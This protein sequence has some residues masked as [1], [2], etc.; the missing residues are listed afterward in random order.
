MAEQ[1]IKR[2]RGINS[3]LDTSRID[4]AGWGCSHSENVDFSAGVIQ[5]LVQDRVINL[6]H[7][8]F[9]SPTNDYSWVDFASRPFKL[10][11][12]EDRTFR[13]KWVTGN[14][15]FHY[16]LFPDTSGSDFKVHFTTS[17]S[18]AP[19]AF[20]KDLYFFKNLEL[21]FNYDFIHDL[22]F[23]KTLP[24]RQEKYLHT[25]FYTFYGEAFESPLFTPTYNFTNSQYF[26]DTSVIY[27]SD[28]HHIEFLLGNNRES[29]AF[30]KSNF[31]WMY[32]GT[33]GPSASPVLTDSTDTA[34]F[35]NESSGDLEIKELELSHNSKSSY[36]KTSG[37]TRNQTTILES[38]LGTS[39]GVLAGGLSFSFSVDQNSLTNSIGRNLPV[40]QLY[41]ADGRT[42]V[43][44]C[45]VEIVS[46]IE[47]KISFFASNPSNFAP[48]GA[49]SSS[50]Y[51]NVNFPSV[52]SLSDVNFVVHL[53]FFS[54]G[55]SYLIEAFDSS[56][57]SIA[58]G[59][60]RTE[61]SLNI[62]NFK[63]YK[64]LSPLSFGSVVKNL[65]TYSFSGSFGSLPGFT[66]FFN[67]PYTNNLWSLDGGPVSSFHSVSVIDRSTAGAS[68]TAQFLSYYVAQ[69]ANDF[70]GFNR[71]T[72]S[73]SIP[74]FPGNSYITH[75]NTYKFALGDYR[76][77]ASMDT[78]GGVTL[79]NLITDMQAAAT[80][81]V[82]FLNAVTFDGTNN[83]GTGFIF[84]NG[85]PFFS[86]FDSKDYIYT[87]SRVLTL[88]ETTLTTTF[89]FRDAPT[90][91][92]EIES[93]FIGTTLNSKFWTEYIKVDAGS[94]PSEEYLDNVLDA[95]L[96][97]ILPQLFI[98]DITGAQV[99]YIGAPEFDGV[100]QQAYGGML[101]GWKDST[102]Y[103]SE[104]LKPEL[105]SNT[106]STIFP[107]KIMG[108]VVG[109]QSLT[110]ITDSTSHMT[111]SKNPEAMSFYDVA[112]VGA[113]SDR[114]V[115]SW[116]GNAVFLSSYGLTV[117]SG[118]G[119]QVLTQDML[120]ANYFKSKINADLYTLGTKH[121]KCY[122]SL[123]GAF[124]YVFNFKS[125]DLTTTSTHNTSSVG[126]Y[127]A[128]YL[129][130]YFTDSVLC[131]AIIPPLG[132]VSAGGEAIF[133]LEDAYGG[134][135]SGIPNHFGRKWAREF[136]EF[137][138]QT[139]SVDLSATGFK[140]FDYLEFTGSGQVSVSVLDDK[141]IVI[142]D[143]STT[144]EDF[145]IAD[146]KATTVITLLA[147]E[148]FQKGSIVKITNGFNG[149][150]PG[151]ENEAYY[152]YKGFIKK[153]GPVSL[154]LADLV[155]F[156]NDV[157][158][159][160]K[161]SGSNFAF[162]LEYWEKFDVDP[163]FDL[164]LS[165]VTDNFL[166]DIK[167]GDSPSELG[168]GIMGDFLEIDA[169]LKNNFIFHYQTSAGKHSWVTRP[170]GVPSDNVGVL[171]PYTQADLTFD[172]AS[173]YLPPV[174][175]DS[176]LPENQL[177]STSFGA[178]IYYPIIPYNG[179]ELDF[180]TLE[181][182]RLYLPFDLPTTKISLIIKGTGKVTGI[183]IVGF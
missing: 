9:S 64:F 109:R 51:L 43:F 123:P 50:S 154:D 122:F 34:S 127:Q 68:T 22:D 177:N 23:P 6:V 150:S 25:F 66:A 124:N 116:E 24:P 52:P 146:G 14:G 77:S 126:G 145:T 94:D 56:G 117:L 183:K 37:L 133:S 108:V 93:I 28:F 80:F 174:T 166:E 48:F 87:G 91:A 53:D 172:P 98:S 11:G 95:D 110:I 182:S 152:R 112:N 99:E 143:S 65:D 90:L 144:S 100:A 41:S 40:F 3:L 165:S 45:Y 57:V 46:A 170:L 19:E 147:G 96:G 74:T 138:Y 121:E 132:G 78:T 130:D 114:C 92:T 148:S 1:T 129:D 4:E 106:F 69:F 175:P 105:F 55:A 161:T 111:T 42:E 12:F 136:K 20:T 151:G 179:F 67:N 81:N 59:V 142:F 181:G 139:S 158:T 44:T 101:V 125:G 72:F 83:L 70:N 76:L 113:I 7:T 149:L 156:T 153:S 2:F 71:L 103:W 31:E 107:S 17:D 140:S 60:V 61:A 36:L 39:S 63:A 163:N 82:S 89:T 119:Y 38:P 75:L 167:S 120:P 13:S 30:T 86:Q 79:G 29:L 49:F 15:N 16:T 62:D 141:G 18:T 178:V 33:W 164:S 73:P 27:T 85:Y 128:L 160:Y 54:S 47:L 159:I 84:G 26:E 10:W 169:D 104:V 21:T 58:P 102:L 155:I 171:S 157:E 88:N 135:G 131:K 115:S 168:Y 162:N 5:P 35:T 173:S 32:N 8:P 134:R 97:T 180:T 176:D 137:T 118:S